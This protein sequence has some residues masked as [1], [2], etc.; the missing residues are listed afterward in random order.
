MEGIVWNCNGLGEKELNQLARLLS[1]NPLLHFISLSEVKRDLRKDENLL[2]I[3]AVFPESKWHTKYTAGTGPGKG[4]FTAIRIPD[5]GSVVIEE[6]KTCKQELAHVSTLVSKSGTYKICSYYV[7]PNNKR[8]S[9]EFIHLLD[10][11]NLSAGDLNRS[12][13]TQPERFR[14]Y[15]QILEYFDRVE[16]IDQPTFIPHTATNQ[17]ATTTPDSCITD[18]EYNE[19]ARIVNHSTLSSDHLAT[20][21]LSDFC[22]DFEHTEKQYVYYA[23]ESLDQKVKESEWN[24]LPDHPSYSEIDEIFSNLLLKIKRKSNGM[25]TDKNDYNPAIH[26]SFD[27]YFDQFIGADTGRMSNV[28]QMFQLAARFEGTENSLNDKKKLRQVSRRSERSHFVKFKD[29][30]TKVK[31][32]TADE[33]LRYQ[34]IMRQARREMEKQA[35]QPEYTI[36]EYDA[37]FGALKASASPGP[38]K[39]IKSLFPAST[40]NKLKI[41]WFINDTVFRQRTLPPKLLQARLQFIDKQPKSEKKRPLCCGQRFLM[42]IT[43]LA[44]ARLG[45]VVD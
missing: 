33:E 10:D 24:E 7:S 34:R 36:A 9:N 45:E 39:I 2:R 17:V 13:R 18:C 29:Q 27:Q 35:I 41:L 44:A 25:K 30:I 43:R 21:F 12:K 28:R 23:Y 22:L 1:T 26:G 11:C 42:L 8:L 14:H 15:K 19:S 40:K 37:E 6:Y 5:T 20:N 32:L 38:D 31:R 16:L 3:S 4:L